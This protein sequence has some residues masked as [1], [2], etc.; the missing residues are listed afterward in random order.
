[1]PQPGEVRPNQERP[2][3]YQYHL[4]RNA[5]ECFSKQPS[6]LSAEE[7][8]KI[9]ARADRSFEMESAVLNSPEADG[10]C[11]PD[12]TLN[13]SIDEVAA[14]YSNHADMLAD[15]ASNG[16][17]EQSL[18]RALH[19]ELLF[20]AVMVRVGS[21]CPQAD[22]L[23][24]ELYYCQHP[25]RFSVDE[26]R[27]ARHILVTVNPDYAE[28]QRDAAFAKIEHIREEIVS[29]NISFPDAAQQ[30]SECPT[31]LEGGVLSGIDAGQLYPELDR[32][33]FRL[34]IGE[35]SPILESELGFHLLLC[36]AITPARQVPLSEVSE[37]IKHAMQQQRIESRQRDW[38]KQL[39]N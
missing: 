28:N 6:E 2:A 19:R 20:D 25:E 26:K 39:T 37:R 21:S 24:A 15:L 35:I 13:R 1:M 32:S 27:D 9:T 12:V 22:D 38:L 31:A 29:G 18:R 34:E 30:F 3:E 7:L 8:Q 23:D 14:R 5:L 17:D 16:L 33:L 4:L 10:L 36:T 11:V